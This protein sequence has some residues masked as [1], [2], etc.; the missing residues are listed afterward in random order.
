MYLQSL[1]ATPLLCLLAITGSEASK[2]PIPPRIDS[3]GTLQA[4]K[5]NY[6]DLWNNGAAAVVVYEPVSNAEA[7]TKCGVTGGK[8][9]PFQNAP[10]LSRTELGYEFFSGG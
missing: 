10:E 7:Q 4:L 2:A 3:L 8:S 9:Y 6:L 5:H 1:A